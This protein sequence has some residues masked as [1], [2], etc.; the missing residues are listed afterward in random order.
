MRKENY[1][2]EYLSQFGQKAAS[3]ALNTNLYQA[4]EPVNALIHSLCFYRCSSLVLLAAPVVSRGVATYWCY[5]GLIV[6][7]VVAGTFED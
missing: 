2:D 6:A 3:E 4:Q 7:A 1:I 5:F